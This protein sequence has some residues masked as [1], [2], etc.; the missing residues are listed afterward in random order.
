M[1][2]SG[3]S[4]TFAD[5]LADVFVHICIDS[6]VNIIC[7]EPKPFIFIWLYKLKLLYNVTHV[8]RPCPQT[9]HFIPVGQLFILY[10]V[11]HDIHNIMTTNGIGVTI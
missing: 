7:P 11:L 8:F 1:T 9:S 6:D 3:Q 4:T 5:L 10:T 2:F